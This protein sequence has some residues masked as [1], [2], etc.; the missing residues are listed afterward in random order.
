MK[1]L[2]L[3]SLLLATFMANAQTPVFKYVD[4]NTGA[5]NSTPWIATNL[6]GNMIIAANYPG[7]GRELLLSDGTATGTTLLKDITSGANSTSFF[8]RG[9]I[10]L[11]NKLYFTANVT[12]FGYELWVTD[13]TNA[14][15]QIVKDIIAGANSGLSIYSYIT[16]LNGKLYFAATDGVKG[17]EL[18]VSDGTAAG[19]QMLKDI[20]P[21]ANSSTPA[22]LTVMNG[23]LYFAADD[24]TNGKE[25]W[26]SDGT[27]PG[28]QM[29]K[30]IYTGINSSSLSATTSNYTFAILNNKILFRANTA[31]EGYELWSSDGTAAGTTLLKDIYPGSNSGASAL[32]FEGIVF[33]G[34]Y[35]FPG[36]DATNGEELWSTDGTGSGTQ[37]VKD[38]KNGSN[39]SAPKYFAIFGNKLVFSA[40]DGSN[41][42]EPWITDGTASGT[43]LIKD[44]FPGSSTSKANYYFTYKNRLYFTAQKINNDIQ[45]WQSDGTDAGTKIVGPS[46]APNANP[47]GNI[48]AS[49]FYLNPT[50]TTIYFSGNYNGDG[51]ELWSMKDTSAPT[52]INNTNA[53]SFSIYPNP[54]DGIF[55]LQLENTD[56]Q[57]G[58]ITVYDVTGKLVYLKKEIQQIPIHKVKVDAPKGI[59]LLKLQLDDAI[60][61]KQIAIE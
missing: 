40:D 9:H 4:I 34:K 28:T 30:D 12:G 53:I 22:T 31:A 61:T 1:Q 48:S 2:I 45:L 14:G 21:G 55:T 13:G 39:S 37:M 41:G 35:Y 51:E 10:T 58:S 36:E 46:V 19:T 23:K 15:T 17:T 24:G 52:G 16:E 50:D 47:V 27:S 33:N 3:S 44:I 57:H 38:I 56:F 11:N 49:E 6:N 20:N 32:F 25:L 26:V 18:W 59:Y 42:E 29:V 43:T 8:G 5:S 60:Q 7:V 54:S